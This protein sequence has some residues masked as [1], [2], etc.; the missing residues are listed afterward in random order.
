MV[1]EISPINTEK[2]DW[3]RIA[4]VT[5][6]FNQGIFIEDTIKSVILQNYPNLEYFI[7]DGGSK[8]E[9]VEII[10]KYELKITWWISGKDHGQAG[11]INRGFK[12]ATGDIIAWIN[13]D[14]RYLPD[15]FYLVANFFKN[16][17]DVDM[18]YGDAEIIDKFGNLIMHRN[19]LE[20]DRTMGRLIGFGI[21][22]T[23]PAVF[24]RRQVLETAGFLDENL[25]YTL[26]SEYW[27]RIADHHKI[28][29]F[30]RV[31]AQYRYHDDAKTIRAEKDAIP[32][33]QEEISAELLS[34]FNK[35][36][37][38]K[39]IPYSYA[40]IVRLYRFKKILLRFLR[41]HYFK[42]YKNPWLFSN[43]LFRK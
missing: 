41:G 22:I 18:I 8:D 11:A 43:P 23:Q 36:L 14:D 6:S 39:Y 16:N 34:S 42:D 13:S 19:E 25:Y 9:T 15:T 12:K 40:K 30:P 1:S 21:L 38:S 37:I 33:A 20:F 3:P 10:K 24:L 31:L 5:P 2:K 28:K 35:L 32:L 7:L 4:I 27:S 26:D 29:H 17:P